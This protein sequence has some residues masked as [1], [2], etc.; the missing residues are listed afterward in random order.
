MLGVARALRSA[1]VYRS[2]RRQ[3]ITVR[4]T[5]DVIIA[6]YCVDGNHVLLYSDQDFNAFVEHLGLVSAL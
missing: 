2:L 6:A 1:E 5:A 4:G 3:G